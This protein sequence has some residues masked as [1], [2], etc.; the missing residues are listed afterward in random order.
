MGDNPSFVM[1]TAIP[2]VL[3]MLADLVT[4]RLLLHLFTI[5]QQQQLGFDHQA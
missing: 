2:S 1:Q 3:H 4:Q 5:F